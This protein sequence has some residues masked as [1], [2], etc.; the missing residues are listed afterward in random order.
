MRAPEGVACGNAADHLAEET[1]SLVQAH[2]VGD[3]FAERGSLVVRPHQGDLRTGVRQHPRRDRVTLGRVGVEQ[4]GRCPSVDDGRELPAQVHR[5]EDAEI[6]S[7]A[8]ERR[9]NVR[10][11]AGEQHAAEAIGG[12]LPGVVGEPRDG[13][14]GGDRHVGTAHS[15]QTPLHLL[16]RDRGVA[17]RRGTVEFGHE[18]PAGDGAEGEHSL[19]RSPPAQGQ[20]PLGVIELDD[21]LVAGQCGAGSGEFKAGEVAHL[22]ASPIAPDQVGR[23]Q[24]ERAVRSAHVDFDP[25]G[26]VLETGHFPEAGN[27][28]AAAH[29]DAQFASPFAEHL[30]QRLLPDAPQAPFGLALAGLV[31]EKQPRE[32]SAELLPRQDGHA[33]GG[34][35]PRHRLPRHR[36]PRHRLHRFGRGLFFGV[37]RGTEPACSRASPARRAEAARLDGVVRLRQ[38]FEDTLL[39]R[40]W[41]VRPR[42]LSRSARCRRSR[43]PQDWS[44]WPG[45]S[46]ILYR[47]QYYLWY[48]FRMADKEDGLRERKKRATRQAISNVATRL[49]TERGFENVTVAQI[50]AAANVAKM[51]VFNY[52]ARKED[53]FFDREDESRELARAALAGRPPRESPVDCLR[54]LAH[55]LVEK[56]HPFAKFTGGSSRFWRTVEQSPCAPGPRG[57][58]V[59][60]W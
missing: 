21:R 12:R 14:H 38:P 57:R 8:A 51:T 53:L 4:L 50:A 49:F 33:R 46:L 19:R 24:R 27:L 17:V 3:D 44:A 11:V 48:N 35:L 6:Q 54:R 15:A 1:V 16:D 55:E 56:E 31:N 22:A 41:P 52:F 25:A 30:L 40:P 5:V 23:F 43:R 20:E 28:V 18:D 60:R 26:R 13:L 36:L 59:T 29:V 45:C 58:C 7:L 10:R 42:A 32:M 9:V 34:G 39:R 47:V 37:H 2:D